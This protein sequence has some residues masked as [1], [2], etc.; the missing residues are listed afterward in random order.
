MPD[1]HVQLGSGSEASLPCTAR[2]YSPRDL[3]AS[4]LAPQKRP[5]CR[6]AASVECAG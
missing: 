4:A 3:P 2:A 1:S 5:E 6:N